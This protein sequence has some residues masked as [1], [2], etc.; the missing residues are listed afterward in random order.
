MEERAQVNESRISR[1]EFLEAIEGPL[2][3]AFTAENVCKAFGVTGT[4]P[5]DRSKIT[6]DKL[7]PA[8]GL[9]IWGMPK[10]IPTSPIKALVTR[11]EDIGRLAVKPFPSL[12][13]LP[14]PLLNLAPPGLPGSSTTTG[15]QEQTSDELLGTDLRSTRAAFLFDGSGSSSQTTIPPLMLPPLPHF[16]PLIPSSNQHSAATTSKRSQPELLETISTLISDNHKLVSYTNDLQQDIIT[17][18]SQITLLTV[19]NNDQ[20][21]KLRIKEKKRQTAREKVNP[22]GKAIEA[23]G[24]ACMAAIEV[25]EG[26]RA[27]AT[28]AK[29]AKQAGRGRRA[30]PKG[31][32]AVE[33]ERR[34]A[35]YDVAIVNWRLER[36][37]LKA[38]GL[39][40]TNAGPE[41]RKYWYL[42]A[43]NPENIVLPT[44]PSTLTPSGTSRPR[45]R[46]QRR[47][48][49]SDS[50]EADIGNDLYT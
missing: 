21:A 41:P 40:M 24:D 16:E 35:L 33:I 26:D 6:S 39:A 4:W 49:H 5:V 2:K 47:V 48:I 8:K 28:A 31:M 34:I 10:I 46:P 11:L 37:R 12:G 43:D 27:A 44:P 14:P 36:E 1:G 19:E 30:V 15:V 3:K 17:L 20:R 18:R 7:A 32:P 13:C 23:T 38:A 22:G 9:A 42:E 50:S 25:Q 45:H 29:A